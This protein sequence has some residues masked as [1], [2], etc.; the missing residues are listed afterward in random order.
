MKDEDYC[1]TCMMRRRQMKQGSPPWKKD[2]KPQTQLTDKS[3]VS[4][5]RGDA[6]LVVLR[7]GAR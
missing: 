6:L 7:T 4:K 3:A 2:A 1:Y 5:K